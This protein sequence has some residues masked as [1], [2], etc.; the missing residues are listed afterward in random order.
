MIEVDF[1]Q[2]NTNPSSP[3]ATKKFT[4]PFMVR[5]HEPKGVTYDTELNIEDTQK[6]YDIQYHTKYKRAGQK[7]K[8]L[9]KLGIVAK[10]NAEVCYTITLFSN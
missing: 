10:Q 8:K 1:A 7:L 3:V 6:Q 5:V 9:Q 4:G 2:E